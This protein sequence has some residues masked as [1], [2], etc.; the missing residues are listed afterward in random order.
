MAAAVRRQFPRE[1]TNITAAIVM[2]VFF[3]PDII[4]HGMI[5]FL[6]LLTIAFDNGS[7]ALEFVRYRV[8]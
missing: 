4:I 3:W 5:R 6:F 8:F 2:R 7:V 1:P